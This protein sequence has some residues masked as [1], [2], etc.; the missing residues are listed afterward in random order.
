M[1]RQRFKKSRSKSRVVERFE[2]KL[3]L[4]CLPRG[5]SMLKTKCVA[6]QFLRNRLEKFSSYEAIYSSDIEVTKEADLTELN[7][8]CIIPF[9]G[10]KGKQSIDLNDFRTSMIKFVI[11]GKTMT[12][13]GKTVFWKYLNV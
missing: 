11:I 1:I 5:Q 10:S 6:E 13:N 7:H 2:D 8:F 4:T 9:K 12:S 3:S